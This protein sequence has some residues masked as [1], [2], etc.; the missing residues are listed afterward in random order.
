MLDAPC[1]RDGAAIHALVAAC[2]PLDL[3]SIYAYLL[4]CEHFAPTCVRAVVEESTVGFVSAYL[5]PQ[6]EEVVFVWQVAVA[7]E[8]RGRGLAGAMLRE[9]M[10]R[11]ATAGC[12]Y[13]ETTV[14][15][16]NAASRSVFHRLAREFGAAV[17][18]HT[19]FDAEDFGG[20]CHER[21]TLIRIG[22][23]PGR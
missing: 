8:Q 4:L 9:L 3:N 1:V 13:L 2:P 10:A 11:P 12:R 7:A 14:S 5:P 16:S 15:P 21:E 6:R 19:L 20:E 17:A 22:P 18:E 23:I